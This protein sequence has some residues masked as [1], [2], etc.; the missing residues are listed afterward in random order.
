[1]GLTGFDWGVQSHPAQRPSWRGHW[2]WDCLRK[3]RDLAD[4]G[5]VG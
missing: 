1:M 5:E 2:D 3:D 4:S